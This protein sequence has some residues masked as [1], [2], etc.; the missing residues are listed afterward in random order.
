MLGLLALM[1]IQSSRLAARVGRDGEPVLLLDQDR[2]RWDQ[3]LIRRGLAA[4]AG[5]EQLAPTP[6]P[7]VLQA[8]IAACHARAARA[9]DTDWVEL[10]DRYEQLAHV[11]PS[12]IVEL[13]RAVAISMAYGPAAALELVDQLRGMPALSQYHLAAQRARRSAGQARPPRRG[14]RRVRAGGVALAAQRA[15]RSASLLEAAP[16]RRASAA[17]TWA[18]GL[19]LRSPSMNPKRTS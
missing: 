8:A 14:A 9:E 6:G 18:D 19:T 10:A 12:P 2:R 16:C 11:Q 7:Y 13:N 5:A 4:L 3:L 1:E 15:R 17:R